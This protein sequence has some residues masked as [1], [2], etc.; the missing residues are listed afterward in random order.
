MRRTFSDIL[1]QAATIH[2]TDNWNETGGCDS[3]MQ[4]DRLHLGEWQQLDDVDSDYFIEHKSEH[5][6]RR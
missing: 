4:N 3:V 1:R 2:R 5:F 6:I